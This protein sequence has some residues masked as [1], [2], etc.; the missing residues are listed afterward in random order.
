MALG[1]LLNA[2]I[3]SITP[4]SAEFNTVTLKYLKDV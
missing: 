2:F 4:T 3:P 1:V